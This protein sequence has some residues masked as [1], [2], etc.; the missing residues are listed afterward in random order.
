MKS[1]SLKTNQ[2]LI[3]TKKQQE[4]NSSAAIYKGREVKMDIVLP[5]YVYVL[6]YRCWS[7]L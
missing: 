1:K 6:Q 3:C 4:N 5:L 7:C 2:R